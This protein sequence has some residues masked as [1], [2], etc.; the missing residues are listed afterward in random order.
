MRVLLKHGVLDSKQIEFKM[1]DKEFA[2]FIG[3]SRSSLWRAKLPAD[4]GRFSL[5]QDVIA[6]VLNKFDDLT[7]EDVFFLDPLYHGCD[8]TKASTA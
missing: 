3:I 6:K 5:G 2:D 8:K 1:T 4:D 7:F